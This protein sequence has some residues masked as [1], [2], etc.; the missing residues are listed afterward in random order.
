MQ[1]FPA[2]LEMRLPFLYDRPSKFFHSSYEISVLAVPS[3]TGSGCFVM[4]MCF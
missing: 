4:K 1:A 2:P 3:G